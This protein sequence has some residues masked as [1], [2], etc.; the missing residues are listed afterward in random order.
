MRQNKLYNIEHIYGN[1]KPGRRLRAISR[2]R[3]NF[4]LFPQMPA[5]ERSAL[6][7]RFDLPLYFVI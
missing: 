4:L 1:P 2:A 5:P 6:K 7:M 3:K